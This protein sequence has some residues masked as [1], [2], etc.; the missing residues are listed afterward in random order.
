M[1]LILEIELDR[2]RFDNYDDKWNISTK[3]HHSHPCYNKMGYFNPMNGNL[4][5]VIS[6]FCKPI[7]CATLLRT[8]IKK[9][10]LIQIEI[11]NCTYFI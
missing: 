11:N 1:K 3:P 2:V 4:E 8:T 7:W 6:L 9:L 5:H 10:I